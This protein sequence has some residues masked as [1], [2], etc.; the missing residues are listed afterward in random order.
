MSD[1][2]VFNSNDVIDLLPLDKKTN[3]LAQEIINESSLNKVQDLTHLFNLNQA[4]KNVIRVMKLNGLLD[5][6]SDQMI[7]RFEKRPGEFSNTDLINYMQVT[8]NA[9]DRAQ[10]QLNLVDESPAISLTQ[11]NVNVE[12]SKLDRDSKAK[13]TEAVSKILQAAQK[14]N[15]N[16]DGND[17]MIPTEFVKEADAVIVD[18][19][20]VE[21]IDQDNTPVSSTQLLNDEEE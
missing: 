9:I 10:K 2:D 4:K 16:L 13:I 3:E 6:V 15:L 20:N 17:N 11:V 18:E 14:M 8:Q 5:K 19:N 21:D 12:E 7:E 1:N